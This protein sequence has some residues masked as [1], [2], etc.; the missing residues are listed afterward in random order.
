MEKFLESLRVALEEASVENKDEI[1]ENY[2]NHFSIGHEAGMTDEEIIERFDSIEDIVASY[3]NQSSKEEKRDFKLEL[4]LSCFEKFDIESID[5]DNIR[6]EIDEEAANYVEVLKDDSSFHLKNKVMKKN[7]TNKNLFDGTL[8]IGRDILFDKIIIGNVAA[9]M[10]ICFLKGNS[11]LINTVTGDIRFDSINASEKVKIA[12]VSGDINLRDICSPNLILETV[13]GDIKVR[14]I[15]SDNVK[16]DTVNGDIEIGVTNEANY[17][18]NS[19]NG[20]LKIKKGDI[21]EVS[22]STLN[23]DFIL[24]GEKISSSKISDIVKNSLNSVFKDWKF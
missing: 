6:L 23:G 8:Y 15:C 20:D 3:V 12:S 7:L 2:L 14:E 17:V 9:D 18:F 16:F 10:N 19:V 24:E 21:K 5:G 1:I 11:I 4:D 22:I 13:N